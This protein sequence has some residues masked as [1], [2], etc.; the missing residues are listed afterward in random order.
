[1]SRH[2]LLPV[3]LQG[4]EQE[5]PASNGTFPP[6]SR[7]GPG[8][9]PSVPCQ[10]TRRYP[11]VTVR[12]SL[13]GYRDVAAPGAARSR[14]TPGGRWDHARQGSPPGCTKDCRGEPVII[15]ILCNRFSFKTHVYERRHAYSG[16][17]KGHPAV[18]QG[19][20]EIKYAGSPRMTDPQAVSGE[21]AS[22]GRE[23]TYMP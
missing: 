11:T 16:R 2:G 20:K 19:Q 8:L 7:T 23:D 13:P 5:M 14:E 10:Q 21:P 9:P 12:A 4:A 1:M 22:H 18:A 17:R 6:R 3:V 15:D